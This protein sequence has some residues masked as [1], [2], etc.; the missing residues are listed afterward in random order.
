MEIYNFLHLSTKRVIA[1]VVAALVAAAVTVGIVVSQPSQFQGKAIVFV[2]QLFPVGK[3]APEFA[4]FI[5]NFDTALSLDSVQKAVAKET[6]VSEGEL[7]R[8]LKAVQ[9]GDKPSVN[10]TFENGNEK[11]AA[12]VVQSASRQGLKSVVNEEVSVATVGK[13]QAEAQVQA[14]EK[15]IYDFEAP[16]GYLDIPGTFSQR[17]TD[18]QTLRNQIAAETDTAAAGR[19]QSV[20]N[21]KANELNTLAPL[22]PEAQRLYQA[23]AA[24]N[25]AYGTASQSL[26]DAQARLG[27]ADSPGIVV[28]STGEVGKL[29]AAARGAVASMVL[30]GAL[31]L[32]V[33]VILDRRRG[34]RP[35][36]VSSS[37]STVGATPAPTGNGNGTGNGVTGNPRPA[38][39][40]R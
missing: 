39:T 30:V 26:S 3:T 5:A 33:F 31:G 34:V 38:R 23:R 16:K 15:A 17:Q 37:T 11:T 1:L 32:L 8:G 28:V 12:A 29:S 10:V 22:V 7:A 2:S 27:A 25:A 13:T 21:A 19:L 18:L 24:A 20:Y 9:P 36:P 6:G 35:A 4:P 14:A 40:Q